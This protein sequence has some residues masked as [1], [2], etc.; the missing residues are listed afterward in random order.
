M[1]LVAYC[2]SSDDDSEQD[3]DIADEEPASGP[4]FALPQP[5]STEEKVKQKDKSGAREI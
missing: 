5:Q 3:N 2:N 1:S 4:S